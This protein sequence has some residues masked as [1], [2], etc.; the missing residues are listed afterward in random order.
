MLAALPPPPGFIALSS[1]IHP[2]RQKAL[3][4]SDKDAVGQGKHPVCSRKYTSCR[5]WR[6]IESF[7]RLITS[8]E[9]I[10]IA[11]YPINK[12]PGNLLWLATISIFYGNDIFSLSQIV[13]W[14][15]LKSGSSDRLPVNFDDDGRM[16]KRRNWIVVDV[17]VGRSVLRT[18]V[19]FRKKRVVG[20]AY[21]WKKC[22]SGEE[23][24]VGG[25]LTG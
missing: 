3:P 23:N 18:V 7:V 10:Y 22:S 20:R 15:S 17:A 6:G 5:P 12:Y 13:H 19:M 21:R 25:G 4:H 8:G 16:R 9:Y 1:R 24:E 2:I 11:K 14:G